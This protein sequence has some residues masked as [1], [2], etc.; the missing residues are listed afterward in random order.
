MNTLILLL[1]RGSTYSP[2]LWALQQGAD[3]GVGGQLMIER[4]TGWLSVLREDEVLEEYDD[5][6]R[7]VISTFLTD[8]ISYL[9]E[10]RGSVLLEELFRSIPLGNALVDNDHGLL[11]PLREVKDLAVESWARTR[12]VPG[13]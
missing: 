7:K 13:S 4:P 1:E 9:I 12:A 11:V 6:E 5:G 10:W 3:R 8:P 2:E